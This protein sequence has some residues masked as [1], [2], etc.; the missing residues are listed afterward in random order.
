MKVVAINSS[1]K[2]DKG[3]TAMIL[4]PFLEGMKAAEA[5]VA[6]YYTNKLAINPCL[7]CMTC[8]FKTPGRCVH[9]DDMTS[10]YPMFK[11][12]DTMVF[13]SPVYVDGISGPMKNLIDRMTPLGNPLI[14]IKDGHTRHIFDPQSGQKN[15]VLVSSCGFWELDTFDPLI[16][17]MKAMSLNIGGRFAGALLRPH[18]GFL[19]S[20]TEKGISL[21]DLFEGAKEAGYELVKDGEMS[22]RTLQKI[23]REMI[24]QKTYVNRIN[25]AYERAMASLQEK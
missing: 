19:K 11:E 21:N 15:I 16:I 18:A 3:N 24:D 10:L 8:W 23:S 1:P 22:E 9:E 2:M 5:E 4:N 12:A 25:K 6:L 14:E 20:L 17:Y 13:S 7:G